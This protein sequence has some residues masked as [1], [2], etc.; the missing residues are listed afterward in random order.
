LGNRYSRIN[1]ASKTTTQL[2]QLARLDASEQGE[3]VEL[4]L[5]ALI[6]EEI[7]DLAGLACG[8]KLEIDIH[9]LDEPLWIHGNADLLRILFRNLILNAF[10]YA[11]FAGE[12]SIS[13]KSSHGPA[14][15]LIAN[16]CPQR[17]EEDFQFMP[18]RF[19]RGNRSDVHGSGLGLSI[20]QRIAQLHQGKLEISAWRVS[21]GFKAEICLPG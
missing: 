7:V 10:T 2:L 19:Y 21:G 3:Y 16:E 18:A 13:L 11:S 8:R 4:D 5:K 6:N 15:F 9:G 1:R 20:V 14:E 17:Q 12:V